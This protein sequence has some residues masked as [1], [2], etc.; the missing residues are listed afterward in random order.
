LPTDQYS[1]RVPAELFLVLVRPYPSLFQV[2]FGIK[3]DSEGLCAYAVQVQPAPRLSS[4]CAQEGNC[5][6]PTG[7]RSRLGAKGV[8]GKKVWMEVQKWEKMM[9]NDLEGVVVVSFEYE[10][11]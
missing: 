5:G 3:G 6:V 11:V 7:S 10:W 1:F 2:R 9:K 8:E 4:R